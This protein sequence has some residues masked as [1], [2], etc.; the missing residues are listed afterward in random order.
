MDLF[1]DWYLRRHLDFKLTDQQALIWMDIKEVLV[2]NCTAQPQV[3]THRDYHSRN[4]M[5]NDASNPAVIDFQ[6]MV[7]GP[8][9]YDLA[10]IFKDCYIAWTRE[11]QLGWL[12]DYY[13]QVSS[14]LRLDEFDFDSLVRW[15]DFAGL[16]RHLK[17]LG[18]F[19]RLHYRDEKSQYLNDLP[20]V[21]HYVEEVLGI[22]PEFK[23]FQR[24][25]NS[26]PHTH[27]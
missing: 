17:V 21:R 10:S 25:F 18:I 8:I 26:L 24:F 9:A 5:V 7:R 4:L 16:Q 19:C 22:Y 20:L 12:H 15:Y 27:P 6:D 11:Q 3:W 1:E 23:V 14:W 13:S 2:K